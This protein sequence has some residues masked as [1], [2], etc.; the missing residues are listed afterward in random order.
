MAAAAEHA[1]AAAAIHQSRERDASP[2]E[3]RSGVGNGENIESFVQFIRFLASTL[4]PKRDNAFE[5]TGAFAIEGSERF[6]LEESFHDFL[7][8][9]R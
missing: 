6:W 8:F 9:L 3:R 4:F 1:E 2:L 5:R 7:H